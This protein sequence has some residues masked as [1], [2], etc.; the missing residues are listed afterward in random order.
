MTQGVGFGF[1][2]VVFV[3]FVRFVR[4]CAFSANH[5]T[6]GFGCVFL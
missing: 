5:L 2:F 6:R 3:F 1:A 4:F